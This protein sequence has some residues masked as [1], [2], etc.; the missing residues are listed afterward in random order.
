MR[1]CR[2]TSTT[3]MAAADEA[4]REW[5]RDGVPME[6][7]RPLLLET[8]NRLLRSRHQTPTHSHPGVGAFG[9][10]VRGRVSLSAPVPA[11]RSCG[12]F[13]R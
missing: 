8:L 4:R 5:K 12:P 10:V 9:G 7:R 2:P 1:G 13:A 3:W 6:Q 11:I